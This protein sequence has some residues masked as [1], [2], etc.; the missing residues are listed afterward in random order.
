MGKKKQRKKTS[1]FL[2]Y[3]V[4]SLLIV[5]LAFSVFFIVQ[6][7]ALVKNDVKVSGVDCVTVSPAGLLD[8]CNSQGVFTCDRTDDRDS[9]RPDSGVATITG[10]MPSDASFIC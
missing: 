4:P 1:K 5:L 7:T 8:A 3:G 9:K 6:Q 2:V 10:Y